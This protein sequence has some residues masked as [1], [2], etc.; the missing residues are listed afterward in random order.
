MFNIQST[1]ISGRKI[2]ISEDNQGQCK[3]AF[4]YKLIRL[5]ERNTNLYFIGIYN[6]RPW[7]INVST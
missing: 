2:I 3:V 1:E 6:K 7:E 5:W 4:K